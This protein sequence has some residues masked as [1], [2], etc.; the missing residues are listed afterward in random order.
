MKLCLIIQNS[1]NDLRD[2]ERAL[3][4]CRQ[5][6]KAGH[7]INCV[8]FYRRAVDHAQTQLTGAQQARQQQWQQWSQQQQVPLV[9]C[10]TVAERVGLSAFADHFDA[11]GLTALVQA[12]A[13]A[14]RTLQ[15]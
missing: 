15:F 7:Q 5:A 2:S 9:V 4:F 11:S 14:D 10:Q 3:R 13:A 12:M 8:F 1:I 6:Q